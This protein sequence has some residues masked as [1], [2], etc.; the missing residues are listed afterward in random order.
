MRAIL[1]GLLA[2]TLAAG[3]ATAATTIYYHAGNWQAF[4]GTDAQ[5]QVICG[6]GTQSA[7]DG[8]S[9]TLTFVIGGDTLF[10]QASKPNWSIPEGTQVGVVMQV[11]PSQPWNEQ[12]TGHGTTLSWSLARADISPFDGQFRVANSMTL[13]FPSGNE[14]PWT[15]SLAGSTA[16][17]D[18][19]AR[20]ITD[21]THREQPQQ[22]STPSGPTQ[23]FGQTG[24]AGAPS[25]PTQPFI[26]GGAPA[27]TQPPAPAPAPTQPTSPAP[28]NP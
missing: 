25:G 13:S 3:T 5:N 26:Q 24:A 28:A 2:T 12:A 17:D 10:F 4:S 14:P 22:S 19:F 8:R 15:I 18:T 9:L 11:G 6:I 23:P 7:E 1:G 20:C 27:A 21:L 16:T